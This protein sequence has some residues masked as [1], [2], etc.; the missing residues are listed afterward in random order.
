MPHK[1]GA[2]K[3]V[4][5]GLAVAAACAAIALA[6]TAGADTYPLVPDGTNPQVQVPVGLQTSNHDE[7]DTTNGQVDLPF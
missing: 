3:R 6:P 4:V 1:E 5:S 2:A 7:T